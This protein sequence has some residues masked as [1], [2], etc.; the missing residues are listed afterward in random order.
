MIPDSV[1]TAQKLFLWAE[2]RW[3][4]FYAWASKHPGLT[5]TEREKVVIAINNDTL[6][7]DAFIKRLLHLAANT[8]FTEEERQ[9]LLNLHQDL[10]IN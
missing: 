4:S 5:E 10:Y 3:P 1:N 7:T 2:E 8:R 9:I 6:G